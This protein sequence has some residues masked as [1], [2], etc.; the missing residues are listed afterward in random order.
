[1]ERS[2]GPAELP[3]AIGSRQ[4]NQ[5]STSQQRLQMQAAR[6]QCPGQVGE[7]AGSGHRHNLLADLETFEYET[8]E[9][10]RPFFLADNQ[11]ATFTG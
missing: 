10:C 8:K 11:L 3:E 6:S 2:C 4:E 1:M 9:L 5:P 7:A